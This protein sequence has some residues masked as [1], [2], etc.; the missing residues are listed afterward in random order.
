MTN[1]GLSRCRGLGRACEGRSSRHD[2]TRHWLDGGG[3]C[4]PSFSCHAGLWPRAMR[5]RR[6]AAVWRMNVLLKVAFYH[7]DTERLPAAHER[8]RA[9]ILSSRY[10]IDDFTVRLAGRERDVRKS[11]GGTRGVSIC[12]KTRQRSQ[13]PASCE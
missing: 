6:V 1:E 2:V 7:V 5:C 12:S 9:T 11:K 10:L 8:H 13:R 4:V 3:V